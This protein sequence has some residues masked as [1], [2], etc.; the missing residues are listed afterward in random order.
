MFVVTSV[1]AWSEALNRRPRKQSKDRSTAAALNQR[2]AR[3]DLYD[4][5]TEAES[6]LGQFTWSHTD[7]YTPHQSPGAP[8]HGSVF[9]F[10]LRLSDSAET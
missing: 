8:D 1:T 5:R 9:C 6:H 10:L 3:V 2:Q 7:S 4:H